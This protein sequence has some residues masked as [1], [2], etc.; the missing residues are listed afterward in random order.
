MRGRIQHGGFTLVEVMIV[1][2]IIALLSALAIPN[3]TRARSRAWK[4]ACIENIR[5]IDGAKQQWALENYQGQ[6]AVPVAADLDPYI[7]GGSSKCI[8]PLDPGGSIAS[9]YTLNNVAT[10]PVCK[11][12]PTSHRW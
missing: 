4:G 12:L 11:K 1:V 2:T 7:K 3:I 10:T 5:A 9:S 8:C 6:S